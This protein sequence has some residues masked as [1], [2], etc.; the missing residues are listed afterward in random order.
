V[1]APTSAARPPSLSVRFNSGCPGSLSPEKKQKTKKTKKTKKNKQIK[2]S[3]ENTEKTTEKKR[4]G[5]RTIGSAPS[6]SNRFGLAACLFFFLLCLYF[7][8][9]CSY[10]HL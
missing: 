1:R 5:K 9:L 8:L 6:I 2:Y 3:K 7:S 4:Q 10:P